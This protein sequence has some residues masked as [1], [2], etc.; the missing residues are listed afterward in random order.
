MLTDV[1][2]LQWFKNKNQYS[3]SHFGMRYQF[4]PQKKKVALEDG[5][6]K[7]ESILRLDI[8]PDPWAIE[9]TDPALRRF[10]EY[11]L[12][13]EGRADAIG[14]LSEVFYAEE[15]RWKSCPG[16]LDCDPWE[17]PPAEGDAQK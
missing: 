3:G 12:T 16:I 9:H 15:D 1:P 13:E 5:T 17:A 4:T 2:L 11:P 7:E 8:W 6:E 10:E 14:H